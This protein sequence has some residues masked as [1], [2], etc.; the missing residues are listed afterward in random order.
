MAPLRLVVYQSSPKLRDPEENARRIVRAAASVE[1]DLLV[2]PE[3]SLTGY[4]VGDDVARLAVA[5]D[6]GCVL[7]FGGLGD[8]A[9]TLVGLVERGDAGI[10]YNTAA[11]VTSG[12]VVF[13]HRKLYLPTYGMFE[14]GRFFGRGG[15]LTTFE[16]AEGWRAGVL[17]CEDFWHPALA[18]VLAAARVHLIV[19]MAAAAGRGVFQGGE[20]G[21]RFA[22]ADVWERM[23]RVTAQLYGVYVVLANRT[24]V[25]GAVTFTGGSLIVGPDGGVLARGPEEGEALLEATLD[26]EEVRRA[27]T[28]YAHARDDDPRL[29]MRLLQRVVEGT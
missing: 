26:P 3:L 7:P 18:Y 6:V 21:G 5:A 8:A 11:L 2:T 23:A 28:P 25:E 19:V 9:P 4:G 27:R 29:T 10:H 1:A 17:I 13:R 12:R 14:E 15:E 16:P 22:S 24:G 20:A